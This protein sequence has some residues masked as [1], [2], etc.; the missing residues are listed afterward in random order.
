LA[1][2]SEF[3]ELRREKTRVTSLPSYDFIKL[4]L[5]SSLLFREMC[6][7][8]KDCTYRHSSLQPCINVQ[9][10]KEMKDASRFRFQLQK[11]RQPDTPSRYL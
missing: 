6:S 9:N 11:M 3:T 4:V 1:K 10:Q 8:H 5:D 7:S 2:M